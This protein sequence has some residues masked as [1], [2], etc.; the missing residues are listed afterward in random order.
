[1]NISNKRKQ[2]YK[3]RYPIVRGEW[4]YHKLSCGITVQMKIHPAFDNSSNL[5]R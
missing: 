1:M 4:V 2:M 3:Y 5:K